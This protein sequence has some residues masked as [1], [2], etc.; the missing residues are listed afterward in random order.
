MLKKLNSENA[1]Q[2]PTEITAEMFMGEILTQWPETI[3]IFF[4]YKM[5]CVG[6]HMSSFDT[7]EDALAVYGL[8]TE[9]VLVALNQS[10]KDAKN[11]KPKY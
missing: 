10:L 6:C 2:S 1:E 4:E 11:P 3:P 7:L 5:T 8:P 9:T